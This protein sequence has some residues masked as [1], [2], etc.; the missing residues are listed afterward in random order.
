MTEPTRAEL[1]GRDTILKLLSDAETARISTA[2]TAANIR[3]GAEYLDLEHIDQGILTAKGGTKV[4]MGHIVPRTAVSSLEVTD[5]TQIW[6]RARVS[7][8][9][10][11]TFGPIKA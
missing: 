1:V 10:E 4:V 3:E 7:G 9:V 11:H 2:E 6:R 5:S 8:Q